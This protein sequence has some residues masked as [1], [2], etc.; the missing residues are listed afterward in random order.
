MLAG[1]AQRDERDEEQ[2]D[3][4]SARPAPVAAVT[5]ALAAEEQARGD[6]VV[7]DAQTQMIGI[8]TPLRAD[9]V[10]F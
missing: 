2:G 8:F 5:A 10:R 3:E 6:R 7:D 1:P 9:Y 4:P